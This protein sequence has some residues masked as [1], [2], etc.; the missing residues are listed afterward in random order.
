M[1]HISF[2]KKFKITVSYCAHCVLGA[3]WGG[4]KAVEYGL[5]DSTYTI[6]VESIARLI[7]AGI[8]ST[9]RHTATFPM[10]NSFIKEGH[11]PSSL[12]A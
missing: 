8:T 11:M 9:C 5:C 7:Q 4:E 3:A 10:L 6:L 2:Q 12:S 1:T